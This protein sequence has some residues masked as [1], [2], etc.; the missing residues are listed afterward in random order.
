MSAQEL[1]ARLRIQ[2]PPVVGRIVEDRLCLDLRTVMSRELGDL[3]R[4]I[5]GALQDAETR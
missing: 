1:E 2:D 3:E 5:R 4:A